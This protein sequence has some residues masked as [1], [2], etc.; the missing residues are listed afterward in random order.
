[1][2]ILVLVA[3]ASLSLRDVTAQGARAQPQSAGQPAP[4]GAAGAASNDVDR[5]RARF[6]T[7]VRAGTRVDQSQADAL[8]LTLSAVSRRPIQNWVRTGGTIDKTGKVLVA[9]VSG[10]DAGLIKAGQRVRAFP[11]SS[12]SSMY[13]AFVTRVHPRAGGVD[14]EATLASVG[15]PGTTL[16]VIEI[17]VER[18]PFLSVPNEAIIEEADKHLV[19][20]QQQ[21]GQYLPQEIQAGIQGELYTQV[22]GGVKDGDQVVTFGSFFIDAEQKLK[23]R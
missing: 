20:V 18:G 21:A 3:G 16:Y 8:T 19:Y 1:M 7:G 23:G 11:P 2:R 6:R 13:Q 10:S 9:F 22:L 17:V 15:R 14:L 4:P 5:V 12:K